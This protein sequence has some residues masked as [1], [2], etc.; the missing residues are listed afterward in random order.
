MSH[1]TNPTLP[2][3]NW[4]R[5]A[6]RTGSINTGP[7]FDHTTGDLTGHYMYIEASWQKENDTARCASCS[8]AKLYLY[9]C[10]NINF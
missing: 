1:T 9:I 3:M 4:L 2:Q 8:F 5:Q 6:G 10:L 7:A